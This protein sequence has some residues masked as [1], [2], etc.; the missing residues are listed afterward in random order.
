MV[1]T[2]VTTWEGSLVVIGVGFTLGVAERGKVGLLLGLEVGPGLGE[3]VGLFEGGLEG[4]RVGSLVL[5]S[6]DGRDDAAAD[7]S[8]LGRS[9]G[10]WDR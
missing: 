8:P 6:S 4:L 1:G 3:G 9:E 7:G 5:G 2:F 10:A